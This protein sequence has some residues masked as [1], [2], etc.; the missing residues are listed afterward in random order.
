MGELNDNE[1]AKTSAANVGLSLTDGTSHKVYV[2]VV[3]VVVAAAA[4]I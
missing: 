3:V 1:A 4:D 2:V